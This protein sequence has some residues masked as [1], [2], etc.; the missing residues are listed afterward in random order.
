MYESLESLDALSP[1]A[2]E[3][4]TLI[5]LPISSI[6]FPVLIPHVIHFLDLAKGLGI[7][8]KNTQLAGLIS[9][10]YFPVH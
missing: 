8:C 2:M 10:I 9:I 3:C 4:Q 6:P 5:V 7:I 1:G